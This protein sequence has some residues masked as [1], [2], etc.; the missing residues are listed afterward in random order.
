[1]V[2]TLAKLSAKIA[3]IVPSIQNNELMS[4]EKD[5]KE[6]KVGIVIE[7]LPNTLFRIEFENEDA[8]ML[9]YLSGRMRL[10]RI[11]VL[12]GDKVEVELDPYNLS[13]GKIVRRL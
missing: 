10:H 1:M 13:K 4:S 11:R 6:K 8:T 9:G 2:L 3:S 12:V 7:A 5:S